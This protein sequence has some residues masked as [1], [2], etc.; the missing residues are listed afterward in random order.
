M[1]V[2]RD[3]ET[4][5]DRIFVAAGALGI[6]S[7]VYDPGQPGLVRW[8][9]SPELGPVAIRPMSFAEANG[10]LYASA[11]GSVYRRMDGPAPAWVFR[12]P[13]ETVLGKQSSL[14]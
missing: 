3:R 1:I 2:H 12:A 5:V 8:D 4:G 13:I 14:R 9:Q 10:R 7:G 6:Y 11:G